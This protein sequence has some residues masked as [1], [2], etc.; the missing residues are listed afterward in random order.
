M[1]PFAALLVLAAAV[2]SGVALAAGPGD[3]SATL[4]PLSVEAPAPVA[5]SATVDPCNGDNRWA[6]NAR[7]Q[8][9]VA[10]ALYVAQGYRLVNVACSSL[11][12]GSRESFDS[13]IRGG[14]DVVYVGFCDDDCPDMD[15]RLYHG[16]S[17][18]A[19]DT[20]VDA[21][22]VIRHSPSRGSE[23]YRLEVSMYRC[24]VEPCYF[25]VGMF[26]R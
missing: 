3:S 4:P 9:V 2:P 12:E 15:L 11:R 22:P 1:R 5:A 13:S 24:R 21:F 25:A 23:D 6:R 7:S 10:G 14:S 20:A 17:E 8:L 19:R 26:T 18:V 16:G